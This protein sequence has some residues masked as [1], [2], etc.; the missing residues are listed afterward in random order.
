LADPT[1]RRCELREMSPRIKVPKVFQRIGRFL[2]EVRLEMK[3]VAWP[4]R[5]ELTSYTYIVIISVL[6][7]AVFIGITDSL[8]A[9]LLRL[10]IKGR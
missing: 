6:V 5:N 3:K 2:K 9:Y 8:F 7:V 4:A 1:E 10:T